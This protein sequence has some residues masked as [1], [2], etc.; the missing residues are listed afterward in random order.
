MYTWG[1]ESKLLCPIS[2]TATEREQKNFV[3]TSYTEDLIKKNSDNFD[4]KLARHYILTP[5]VVDRI[6]KLE[7]SALIQLR[8]GD[9][10]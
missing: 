2:R 10:R 4:T 1:L 9:S 3:L 6:R 8:L 5:L 7:T